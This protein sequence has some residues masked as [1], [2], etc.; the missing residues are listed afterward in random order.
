M[1]AGQPS[2]DGELRC[3]Q[4]VKEAVLKRV[5]LADI[6]NLRAEKSESDHLRIHIKTMQ[7]KELI[8][9]MEKECDEPLMHQLKPSIVNIVFV[10]MILEQ[11]F[12]K[13]VAI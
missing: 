2:T 3:L 7:D 10:D 13:E 8:I 12:K 9:Q 11:E 1:K 4:M 6:F 5:S